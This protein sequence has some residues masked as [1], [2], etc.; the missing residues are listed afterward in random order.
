MSAVAAL[1]PG[2]GATTAVFSVVHAALLRPLAYPD[3]ERLFE[4]GG[5]TST[6]AAT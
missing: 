6:G 5:L 1:A 2:I 3:S 4:V